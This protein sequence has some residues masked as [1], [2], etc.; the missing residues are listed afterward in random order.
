MNDNVFA[1]PDCGA[2]VSRRA[3]SCPHCGRKIRTTPINLLAAIILGAIGLVVIG[4][5]VRS[6]FNEAMNAPPENPD[7][8]IIGDIEQRQTEAYLK[9]LQDR[10]KAQKK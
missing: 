4:A 3:Y 8:K 6:A 7:S 2:T 9:R 5:F 1:C 10:Q